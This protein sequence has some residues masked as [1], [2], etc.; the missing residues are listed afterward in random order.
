MLL[1]MTIGADARFESKRTL[2]GR[3]IARD[4]Y[5]GLMRLSSSANV[6]V[7]VVR[8][9]KVNPA[10]ESARFIRVRYEGYEAK[11][12]LPPGLLDGKKLWRFSLK[13]D[14]NCDQTV[15]EGMF[16]RPNNSSTPPTAGSYVLL[17]NAGS[18]L[19]KVQTLLSCF[20]VQSRGIKSVSLNE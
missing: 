8:V 5:L 20:R 17:E 6:E 7:F 10:G 12:P 16:V 19:P 11:P 9:A 18:D 2:I 14:E 15:S 4:A 13:R 1:L 3:V